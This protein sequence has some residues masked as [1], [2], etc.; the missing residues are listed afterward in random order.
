MKNSSLHICLYSPY[1]PKHFGGGEKYF[2]DV[3]HALI[4]RHSVTIAVPAGSL[5]AQTVSAYEHFLGYSLTGIT[6]VESPLSLGGSSV[7]K[8]WWTKQFDALYYV[9]DGS[10]FFS[11]AGR[12]IAHIQIP[13]TEPQRGLIQRA[14]LNLWSIK[15]AN[16]VFT[17]Q[18][19][20]KAWQTKVQ[21][22]HYPM[23]ELPRDWQ[24][25]KKEKII[26]NVGRFF[27]QLHSKRQDILVETFRQLRQQHSQLLKDWQLVLIGTSEDDAY[28]ESVATAAADLPVTIIHQVDRTQLWQWYN[29]ASIYWHAAGFGIDEA[30]E[31]KKVEHFGISTVEA[32]AAGCVPIVVGKGGQKEVLGEA[33]QSL[34]WQTI[35]EAVNLTANVLAD[36]HQTKV[37]RQQAELQAKTFGQA[38]FEETL[39]HMLS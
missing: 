22:V 38:A 16:S 15:N 37:W 17:Q 14:K 7:K 4:K 11:L 12:N 28:A 25:V 39:W 23:I 21:Y 20:E 34:Q 3:A 18:Q 32:M 30:V 33:L 19:I 29:R 5:T 13:F 36:S 8:L 27:R 26:L 1:V 9:T 10:F 6:W 35:P 2:F 31:P 24:P